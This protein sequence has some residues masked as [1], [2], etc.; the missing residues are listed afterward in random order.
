MRRFPPPSRAQLMATRRI[1]PIAVLVVL[2]LI[3][4]AGL[5]TLWRLA[6]ALRPP[7]VEQPTAPDPSTL[8]APMTPP[9]LRVRRAAGVLARGGNEAELQARLQPLLGSVDDNR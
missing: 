3:P 7:P 2:A 6:V 1:N 5:A 4:A 9:L 8:P